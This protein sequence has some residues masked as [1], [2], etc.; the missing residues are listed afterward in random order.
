RL[1]KLPRRCRRVRK[2][3]NHELV[4]AADE[5]LDGPPRVL[6]PLW[7][8]VHQTLGKL[9]HESADK[10]AYK[11]L[12]H[13][14]PD[15]NRSR[16]ELRQQR[17]RPEEEDERLRDGDTQDAS[18]LLERLPHRFKHR[19][20]NIEAAS[21]HIG[22]ALECGYDLPP[23]LGYKAPEALEVHAREEAERE[24]HARE[25]QLPSSGNG[26]QRDCGRANRNSDVALNRFSDRLAKAL[27]ARPH[28][29]G[30]F[31][32]VEHDLPAR[33]APEAIR[34]AVDPCIHP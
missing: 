3:S 23:N 20:G 22:G 15:C 29:A 13:E 6:D 14:L 31:A 21:N 5:I 32:D 30:K 4:P 2:H 8:T 24:C 34:H 19:V 17:Y 1:T 11:V 26:K 10:R 16:D 28:L 25:R 9:V 33:T 27:L 7:Q 18:E 12:S